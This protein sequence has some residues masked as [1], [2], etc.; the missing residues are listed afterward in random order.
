[1][2][3]EEKIL[4]QEA[5]LNRVLG[6]LHVLYQN[7]GKSTISK[8][9]QESREHIDKLF[10]NIN[11]ARMLGFIKIDRNEI[12][13]TK[14]GEGVYKNDEKALEDTKSRL[15]GIEP[16]KTALE[17]LKENRSFRVWELAEKLAE[18][19]ISFAP[20]AKSNYSKLNTILLQWAVYYNI[21]KYDGKEEKWYIM[22]K[23]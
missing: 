8:I 21:L 7:K 1:M 3:K 12:S 2:Q 6:I 14:L 19:G 5:H 23:G 10:P 17:L 9:T 20:E 4:P 16:F 11:A 13:L 15:V 22:R 18:N